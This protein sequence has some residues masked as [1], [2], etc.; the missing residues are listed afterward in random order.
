MNINDSS[1]YITQQ[2]QRRFLQANFD[3]TLVDGDHEENIWRRQLRARK[4]KNGRK[5]VQQQQQQVEGGLPEHIGRKMAAIPQYTDRFHFEDC[6][7]K[8]VEECQ[9]IIDTTVLANPEEFN[10]QTSLIMDLRKIREQLD[11]SYYKVVLRTNIQGTEVTGILDDGVVY[12]P[13]PWVVNGQ[14]NSIGPWDCAQGG[15]NMSPQQCC[16][17]IQ[18]DVTLPDD[19]GNYLACFVEEPVGG[20]NNPVMDNRAIVIV[21]SGGKVARAPI[22]H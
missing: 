18:E 14:P 22:N 8:T 2:E 1:I 10:N 6:V 4:Q 7:G 19:N 12:Y 21:D 5:L 13:W 16:E 11:I 15:V 17:M 9:T 20:P 3:E